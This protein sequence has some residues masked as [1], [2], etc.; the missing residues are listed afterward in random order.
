MIDRL[1][2]A[3]QECNWS[4]ASQLLSETWINNSIE[5]FNVKETEPWDS[6]F[7]ETKINDALFYPFAAALCQDKNCRDNDGNPS[8]RQLVFLNPTF[9]FCRF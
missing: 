4:L 1:L 9:P 7:D 8:I 5:C 2:K 6:Q 3:T